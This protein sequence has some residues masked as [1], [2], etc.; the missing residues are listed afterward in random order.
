MEAVSRGVALAGSLT[1]ATRSGDTAQRAA[2][3]LRALGVRLDA[4]EGPLSVPGPVGTLIVANHVSWLD[5]VGLLALEPA[6]FLAKREVANWPL[7]GEQARRLDTLFVDR[8]A[9]RSLPETVA[10]VAARLREGRS[11]AVFPEA[12][13]YCSGEGGP[14]RRAVF[15]A[16]LDAGAPVRPV[17]LSYLQG[18]LP[19]TVAAFVGDDTLARSLGRV[20]RASG[21]TLRVRAHTALAPE[22][23]RKELAARA[24]RAVLAAEPA[25]V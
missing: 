16:A 9:L 22:G 24:R 10:A 15:Q 14:F 23:D 7:V 12:T 13:T 21:L 18:G 17:T 8:W 25:H 3:A 20:T 6:A 2:G 5:I 19:S 11:V 1:R 4:D